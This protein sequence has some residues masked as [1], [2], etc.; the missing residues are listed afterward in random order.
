MV[1]AQRKPLPRGG[2][3]SKSNV[4]TLFNNS[5]VERAAQFERDRSWDKKHPAFSYLIPTHLIET[6]Q[7]ISE[8]INS[9]AEFDQDGKFRQ[10]GTTSSDMA[11]IFIDY[12]I[13]MSERENL[14]FAPT[15]KGKMTLGWEEAEEGWEQAKLPPPTKRKKN[16][17][18]ERFFLAYRWTREH[19]EAIQNL[20]GNSGGSKHN[21]HRYLVPIG[22]VVVRLLQR[23]LKDYK[24]RKMRPTFRPEVT[25]KMPTG[26]Q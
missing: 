5:D 15:P 21:P 23:A 17:K 14:T 18:K 13:A 26:W 11:T 8:A 24:T 22:E 4:G 1:K 12:A 25:K 19:H 3:D 16:K 6:A 9:A 2:D 7:K 10:D 20:A